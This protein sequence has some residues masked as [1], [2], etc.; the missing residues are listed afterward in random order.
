MSREAVPNSNQCN[1]VGTDRGGAEFC[2]ANDAVVDGRTAP[3]SGRWPTGPVRIGDVAL[4]GAVLFS[5]AVG[6]SKPPGQLPFKIPFPT[7]S[8]R[9]G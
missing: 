9:S 3:K 4:R 8:D 2:R 7:V 1:R 5:A 6:V